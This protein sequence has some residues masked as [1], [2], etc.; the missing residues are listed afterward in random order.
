MSGYCTFVGRNLVT[1][2]SK[3]HNVA[4]RRSVKAKFLANAHGICNVM[5][6]RRLL[7]ELMVVSP[8]PIK[9]YSNNKAAIEN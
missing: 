4:A 2:R 5:W 9:V 6:I 1:W 7:E 3:K 8:S